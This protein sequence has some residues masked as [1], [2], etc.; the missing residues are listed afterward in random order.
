MVK[1]FNVNGE[2]VAEVGSVAEW[3]KALFLRRP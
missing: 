2:S 3:V 1:A